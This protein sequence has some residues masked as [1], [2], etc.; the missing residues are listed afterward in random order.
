MKILQLVDNFYPRIGGAQYVAGELAR[1]QAARGDAVEIVVTGPRGELPADDTWNGIAVHRLDFRAALEEKNIEKILSVRNR[2]KKLREAIRPDVTHVHLWGPGAALHMQTNQTAPS[3][4]VVT[5]HAPVPKAAHG[6][7]DN[8]GNILR[9]ASAVAAVSDYSRQNILTHT[10]TASRV[11]LIYNAIRMPNRSFGALPWE[12][13]LL[14]CMGRMV[15]EKGFDVAVEAFARVHGQIPEARLVITGDGPER[16]SLECRAEALGVADRT[17]FPGWVAADQLP[18]VLDR[19][20]I[21]LV[22]S[23]GGVELFGLVAAE[24][25]LAGRPVVAARTGG[26]SEVVLDGQ[27]GIVIP[28]DDVKAMA[29]AITQLLRDRELATRLGSNAAESARS[30]FGMERFI[31]SYDD[32]YRE[33]LKD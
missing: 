1:A 24:A 20:T 17:E 19:S 27:T 11:R 32:L 4:W 28:V 18:N 3:P 2:M 6:S 12:P 5:V 31:A 13:P 10:G 21:V 16:V 15:P 14:L 22:P 8:V 25:A 7:A 23:R 9:T 29:D 30:R 33:V 26:L